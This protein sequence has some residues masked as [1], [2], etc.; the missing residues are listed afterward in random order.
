MLRSALH[1]KDYQSLSIFALFATLAW[2][3]SPFLLI[4]AFLALFI[5]LDNNRKS[6]GWKLWLPL[7]G[8]ILAWNIGVTWW[9]VNSTWIGAIMAFV[10]NSLFMTLTIAL[11]RI[12]TQK[13]NEKY[14]YYLFIPAWMSF[15]LLH[16]NWE[17]TWS[18]LNLG[19][20]LATHH[21]LIQFYEYT[22]VFGGTL[23]LLLIAVSLF[24]SIKLQKVTY[25]YIVLLASL[26][27]LISIVLWYTYKESGKSTEVVVVQPN[28][29]SYKEKFPSSERFIPYDEQLSRML[30]LTE[31][32]ISP[33]TQFVLWPETSLP[34][35]YDEDFIQDNKHIVRIKTFI[36]KNPHITVITGADTYKIYRTLYDKT[37]TSRFGDGVG[38]YDH[39]NSAVKIDK[40]YKTQIYHKSKL[41]PG[42]ERMPYPSLFSW[43]SKMSIDLGGT[44]G[45]LG[46]QKERTVFSN[47]KNTYIAPVICY[48]SI[49]GE[50][51]GEYCKKGAQ[52]IGIITNDGWW[53]NTPGHVQH[54]Q[55]AKLRAIETRKPIARSANTGISA[56]INQR[57]DIIWQNQYDMQD[58]KRMT[59]MAN[60]AITFYTKNGDYLGWIA[61]YLLCAN[62]LLAIFLKFKK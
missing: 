37:E 31:A 40:N 59:I 5:F 62:V 45:S 16:L 24:Y 13:V 30:S 46:T 36:E 27:F 2:Y 51:V 61:F 8:S 55:L 53:G 33:S 43:L 23:L 11:F 38:W 6:K 1:L 42:V 57:G 48:E 60:D 47:D 7:Y 41:V 9:I 39:F 34:A 29:D 44:T 26:P 56:F 50:F 49:F 22:G 19:N 28:I 25:I 15:E 21:Q 20:A 32:E 52:I 58:S 12:L 17:L 10:L 14:I 4:I 35:G 3:I 18:W 54:L